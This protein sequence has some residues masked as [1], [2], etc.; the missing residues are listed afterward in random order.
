MRI[1]DWS[2]D[3][4]SSDLEKVRMDAAPN[5]L[6][7]DLGGI[8]EQADRDGLAL[9]MGSLDHRDRLVDARCLPVEIASA[10]A[11]LDAARLAFDR[12][13]ARARHHRRERLRAAHAA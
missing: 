10:K 12:E 4:C 11:H 9:G 2:S 5:D 7:Q 6:G 3:V 1:S 8:A 13:T